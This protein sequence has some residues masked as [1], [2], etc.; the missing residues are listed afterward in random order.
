M[1][2]ET[3]WTL[4]GQHTG[5]TDIPLTRR[6]EQQVLSAGS[7][8]V[9]PSRLIHPGNVRKVWV[10][11]RKRALRTFELLFSGGGGWL[12][13]VDEVKQGKVVAGV[14]EGMFGGGPGSVVVSEQIREWD[15]GE[16][17][18]MKPSEVRAMR[19][20]KGLDEGREWSVWR[21]GC[22]GGE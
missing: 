10:S 7:V 6:G 9:G 22:E 16:Y 14:N 2:G 19:K 13:W 12:P 18:G 21:D 20:E 11:P 5:T 3:E 15:Y 8:L 4:S 17:E 1:L